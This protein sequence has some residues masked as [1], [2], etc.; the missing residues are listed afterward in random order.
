MSLSD[1][2]KIDS[3]C[4]HKFFHHPIVENAKIKHHGDNLSAGFT[5]HPFVIDSTGNIGPRATKFIKF[6]N[7]VSGISSGDTI[8]GRRS[9]VS[10]KE[11]FLKRRI[12]FMCNLRSAIARENALLQL[13]PFRSI[14]EMAEFC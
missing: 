14:P 10:W 8:D 12:L 11:V 5:L 4:S 2:R 6:I 1:I 7:E 3:N 9:K 13:K